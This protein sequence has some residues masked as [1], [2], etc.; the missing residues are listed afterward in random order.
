V[1]IGVVLFLVWGA[2]DERRRPG[3]RSARYRAVSVSER[4]GQTEPPRGRTLVFRGRPVVST[5]PG[6]LRAISLL[7][8]ITLVL[9][10]LLSFTTI[11]HR[12]QGV[13]T[14]AS[15]QIGRSQII[16]SALSQADA[17]AANSFLAGGVEPADQRARY[18]QAVQQ[19]MGQIAEGA[20][21]T[22]VSSVI[23]QAVAGMSV[24]IPVYTGLVEQ[25]RANNRQGYPVGTAYLRKASGLMH[26]TILPAA[27]S[28]RHQSSLRLAAGYPGASSQAGVRGIQAVAAILLVALVVAQVFLR[29]HT[30]RDLNLGLVAATVLAAAVVGW[31]LFAL[32]SQSDR[33]TRAQK[34]ASEFDLLAQA[35]VTALRASGEESLALLARGDGTDLYKAFDRDAAEF[36]SASAG[37]GLIAQATRNAGTGDKAV[38][39]EAD[40]AFQDYLSVEKVVQALDAAGE[41]SEASSTAL[42]A[43][44]EPW[45]RFDAALTSAMS[46]TQK[47]FTRSIHDAQHGLRGLRVGITLCFLAAS[48][49]VFVGIQLRVKEYD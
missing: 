3:H 33:A 47:Q 30:N 2:R 20:G 27:G 44:M 7:V 43:G 16:E 24:A 35:H 28:L 1:G 45:D 39:S 17:S 41:S 21:D 40:R 8:L 25:A 42:R 19:V 34:Q 22:N 37:K 26:S 10:W 29:R 48:I 11:A 36:G 32:S 31:T 13:R 9:I 49:L 38:L 46:S 18:Q 12:E 6:R 5:T 14:M 23:R 15:A 4:T